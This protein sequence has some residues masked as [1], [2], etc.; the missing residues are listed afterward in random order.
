MVL[1]ER[2]QK[3]VVWI[4]YKCIHTIVSLAKELKQKQN[5]V[6][7]ISLYEIVYDIQHTCLPGTN[8]DCQQTTSDILVQFIKVYSLSE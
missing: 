8:P 1:I 4:V 3:F 6:E 7:L 5:N 2:A